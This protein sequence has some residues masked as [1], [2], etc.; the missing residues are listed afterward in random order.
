MQTFKI[1][2]IFHSLQ[3]EGF[4]TGRP[5]TFVRLANCNLSCVW[6]D[7][8]FNTYDAMT[9]DEILETVKDFGIENV[10]ITGGEP[11]IH[12]NLFELVT[13]LKKEGYWLALETNGINGLPEKTH[14]L[15]DYVVVSPKFFYSNFYKESEALRQADEVRIVVDGDIFDFC[16]F[17]EK[18]IKA[19][20]Y[21]LSPCCALDD[22]FNVLETIEILGKLNMRKEGKKWG[23][24]FQTHKF[25]NIQ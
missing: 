23:L 24:S 5:V 14:K 12:D 2:E 3:G 22:T 25:A 4:N 15:F 18:R 21:Y 11:T 7:T 10:V 20:Y 19:T 1:N 8:R 13:A 9:L 6:C 17:I 16:E